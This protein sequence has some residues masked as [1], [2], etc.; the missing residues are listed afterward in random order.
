MELKGI[1]PILRPKTSVLPVMNP[2]NGIE[3]LPREPG[4][5]GDHGRRI[6]SME[7]KAPGLPNP[8]GAGERN[9]FNG[10]ER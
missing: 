4:P 10:I 9:P 7:L 8:S 1:L 5:W 2:F 6:H 3:S